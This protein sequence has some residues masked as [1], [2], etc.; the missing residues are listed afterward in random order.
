MVS[1]IREEEQQ[2]PNDTDVNDS[3]A[4]KQLFKENVNAHRPKTEP[5]NVEEAD[6]APQTD[7]AD[8]RDAPTSTELV[9]EEEKDASAEIDQK[10][11]PAA[12]SS[13]QY[14]FLHA[15]AQAV[16]CEDTTTEPTKGI[17]LEGEDEA[18]KGVD[19]ANAA[20]NSVTVETDV[21]VEESTSPAI[22]Q[23]ESNGDNPLDVNEIMGMDASLS[24]DEVLDKLESE[25]SSKQVTPSTSNEDDKN[26]E[27]KIEAESDKAAP[28]SPSKIGAIKNMKNRRKAAAAKK[29]IRKGSTN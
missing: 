3:V 5:N 26:E 9:K 18:E 16:E 15:V 25:E 11:D 28:K 12:A 2:K 8:A 19:E 21:V 17:D 7:A 20:L 23:K 10:D 14:E 13:D 1:P 4:S 29:K 24:Y 22:V 27:K 6:V